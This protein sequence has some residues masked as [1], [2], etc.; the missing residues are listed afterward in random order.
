M[1]NLR[2]TTIVGR[3]GSD[4]EFVTT[5]TGKDIARFSVAVN[6]YNPDTKAEETVWVK[7]TAWDRNRDYVEKHLKNGKGEMVWVTGIHS[8]YEPTSG[9]KQDQLNVKAV[10][11]AATFLND[12]KDS[13]DGDWD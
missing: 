5:S 1:S 6:Q 13:D 8:L 10:G 12:D 7:C 11:I 4:P 9:E 2:Q 3:L